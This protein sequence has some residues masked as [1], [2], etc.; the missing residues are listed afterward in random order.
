[1]SRLLKNGSTGA[2]VEVLQ[3]ALAAIH[4]L[5]G[6]FDKIFGDRTEFAVKRLQIGYGISRDGE[7]GPITRNRL[8]RGGRLS[9]HFHI[10]EDRLYSHGNKDLFIEH[11]LIHALEALRERL[12]GRPITV[13]SCYRDPEYNSRP[14]VDGAPKSQHL[15]GRAADI[16]IPGVPPGL[17]ARSAAVVGFTGIGIYSSSTHVDIRPV[18][19]ARWR[20]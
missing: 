10:I 2:D 9:A 6:A 13:I 14:D 7:V 12:G 19:A 20:G 3:R 1:M 17:V 18:A 8:D 4:F 15:V 11:E 5:P 16:V